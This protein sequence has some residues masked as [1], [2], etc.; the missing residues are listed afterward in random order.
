MRVRIVQRPLYPEMYMVQY[1]NWWHIFWRT[2][3]SSLPEQD[4]ISVGK[5]LLSPLIAEITQ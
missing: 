3:C 1:K 2:Y 4:A 5:R